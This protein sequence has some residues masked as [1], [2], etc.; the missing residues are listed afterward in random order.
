ML[1]RKD[2]ALR[3]LSLA[4]F[5]TNEYC[6]FFQNPVF[7]F[8]LKT[9]W[10]G[11]FLLV[12]I[13]GRTF[14][15]TFYSY[16]AKIF[17]TVNITSE[18]IFSTQ[19]ICFGIAFLLTAIICRFIIYLVGLIYDIIC[20]VTWFVSHVTVNIRVYERQRTRVSFSYIYNEGSISVI[21]KISVD[22][23]W[24]ENINKIT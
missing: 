14:S 10:N 3:S 19:L 9:F 15:V 20:V 8:F 22:I 21:K 6:D 17:L 13:N 18:K 16:P 4:S 5:C 24:N 7:G 1:L 23:I 12:Y 2:T 11:D